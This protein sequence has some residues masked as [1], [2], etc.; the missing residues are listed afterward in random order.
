MMTTVPRRVIFAA[1]LR[2]LAKSGMPID[3]TPA[4]DEHLKTPIVTTRYGDLAIREDGSMFI[5]P[6]NEL[7]R[8]WT[9]L[10]SRRTAEPFSRRAIGYAI[11]R[12]FRD[13][14]A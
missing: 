13:I 12:Y 6:F 1:A 5:R 10:R 9:R 14:V 7:F 8:Q 3:F 2:S 11:S 4:L